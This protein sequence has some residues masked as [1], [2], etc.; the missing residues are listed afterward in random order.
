MAAIVLAFRE[1]W[2]VC[3]AMI[4]ERRQCDCVHAVWL[5][6][7][8]RGSVH[9][10]ARVFASPKLECAHYLGMCEEQAGHELPQSYAARCMSAQ[11]SMPFEASAWSDGRGRPF[12]L[13]YASWHALTTCWVGLFQVPLVSSA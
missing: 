3:C 10:L 1:S 2:C 5:N 8:L 9:V 6:L 11:H 13:H 7:Q 4:S 12:I